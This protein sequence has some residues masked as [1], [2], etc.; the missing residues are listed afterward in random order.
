[1]TRSDGISVTYAPTRIE[2]GRVF[3]IVLHV[4]PGQTP[5]NITPPANVSLVDRTAPDRTGE[6]IFYFRASAVQRNV[7]FRFDGRSAG[8]ETTVDCLDRTG[9]LERRTQGEIRLPRR[10]PLWEDP[11]ELKQSR[12]I[13]RK[14]DLER[15]LTWGRAHPEDVSKTR[16]N[17]DHWAAKT[18]ETLWEA[19]AKAEIPR[20]HFV[21]MDVGCPIHGDAIFKYS[22]YYPWKT[23]VEG[24]PYQVQCPVG[25]EWY[26]SNNIEA[27]D[28]TSGD[29][30]DDGYGCVKGDVKWAFVGV[31]QNARGYHFNGGIK[32][33]SDAYIRTGNETFLHKIRVMLLRMADE[34]AYL[35]GNLEDRFRF[36]GDDLQ[37]PGKPRW[38]KNAQTVAD[39][40]RS[41]LINYCISLAGDFVTYATAYDLAWEGLDDD[42]EFLAVAQ[43]KLNLTSGESVRR[44]IEDHVFRV[45]AQAALDGGAHSNLPHPQMGL[46]ALTLALNY[47]IGVKLADWLWNGGG[48]MRYWVPNF[49]YRD[50]S[51]YES[52]GGYN[53]MHVDATPPIA[54]GLSR[55]KELRPDEYQ[56]AGIGTFD[57]DPKSEMLF[58]HLAELICIG[59]MY[60]QVGDGG[61]RPQEGNP[62]LEKMYS[63]TRDPKTAEYAFE[64]YRDPIFAQILWAGKGYEPG[65]ESRISREAVEAIIQTHGPD[66]SLESQ[67]FDGYGIAVLR[68]GK[69]DNARALWLRYGHARGH[70]QDDMLDIGL[71]AHKRNL[72][73][74]L[75]YP[76][77]WT[78]HG[79]WDGN[80]L[81]HYRV[82]VEGIQPGTLYRGALQSFALTP[83]FQSARADGE[84]FLDLGH[85]KTRYQTFPDQLYNRSIALIDINGS[86]FYALDIHRVKG[87]TGHWWSFRGPHGDVTEHDLQNVESWPEGTPAG[88]NIGYGEIEK[89]NTDDPALHS[90][91]HLYNCRRGEING[92]WG[93]TWKLSGDSGL[94]LRFRQLAQDGEVIIGNGK[95]PVS[96][97]DDPPYSFTWTLAHRTGEA[98]L[99]SQFINL[100]E[101]TQ[102]GTSIAKTIEQIPATGSGPF[103]PVA[104]RV[105]H[106][107]GTDLILST[108][109]PGPITPQ[110]NEPWSFHGES[111]FARTGKNGI[112]K[113]VLTN[114]N[115]FLMDGIGITKTTSTFTATVTG[116]D[117][118]ARQ[119][120]LSD[121][122]RP[123]ENLG[124]Q[125]IRF[126][127]EHRSSTYKIISAQETPQGVRLTLDID[128]RIG[129][130]TIDEIEDCALTTYT[131]FPLAGFRYYQGAY[132]K[133]HAGETLLLDHVEPDAVA[134]IESGL[135]PRSRIAFANPDISA[136]H[137]RIFLGENSTF[138]VYD[139]GIGSTA[140]F[141]F[142]THL[143]KTDDQTWEGWIGPDTVLSLGTSETATVSRGDDTRN[144]AIENDGTLD[145]SDL[146]VGPIKIELKK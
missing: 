88:K 117:F 45:G 115:H 125:H 103:E 86:D 134:N 15:A 60:P 40:N 73:S 5:V 58:R 11:D 101:S 17:A 3:R 21:N 56:N 93:A 104:V 52:T 80:W 85:G 107:A 68:S 16:Q 102:A 62:P 41:G 141:T 98:P 23:D 99:T 81:T 31:Y 55:L 120:I 124:G 126:T 138:T 19:I 49:F 63:M 33:L 143:Q 24:H 27:D 83:G 112:E 91:A 127:S 46:T 6:T 57:D 119:V 92:P 95:P 100:I 78:T 43:Q 145:L 69:G 79:L 36:G 18:D 50:G 97:M 59:R 70:R 123:L 7:P 130:G 42:R 30:P 35:S 118:N 82:K 106:A 1:M 2:L 121:A 77:T 37:Y 38:P 146:G 22:G 132:L 129:E 84:A 61:G 139:L 109:E 140:T 113:I 90:L 71:F 87:G 34:W 116:G 51:A 67:T 72:L 9:I 29:Y 96:S 74:Q 66:I 135:K 136:D 53:G 44:Y 48:Q 26:G 54:R 39:I 64:I 142:T 133:S 128:I 105:K 89:I 114:G 131:H 65:P 13:W 25:G 122:P 111:G 12:T 10:W 94:E 47:R 137:L 4:P 8:A 75:G 14:D 32:A 28:F 20:W 76:Y 108:H 144:I 110:S